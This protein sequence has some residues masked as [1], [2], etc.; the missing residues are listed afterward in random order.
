MKICTLA[1]G[2]NFLEKARRLADSLPLPVNICESLPDYA[3]LFY[4]NQTGR[5]VFNTNCKR[6][7]IKENYDTQGTLCIDSDALCTSQEEF[8]NCCENLKN[9]DPGIYSPYVFSA[10]GFG[11]PKINDVTIDREKL[12]YNLKFFEPFIKLTNEQ[13][14]DFY[15]PWE[16]FYFFKFENEN[17]K[18]I[19]FEIWDCL[20][21]YAINNN[22]QQLRAECNLI[23]IAA[24]SCGLKVKQIKT[25][26][27][28]N[29][30]K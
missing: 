9:S 7:A 14:F 1:F 10:Y 16:W 19:F 23:G 28:V 27:G 18:N 22:N 29:H 30:K 12:T 13:L 2:K 5:N 24:L 11:H 6:F 25:K 3:N 4:K 20:D 21:E 15:M 17:Q 26:F 8:I